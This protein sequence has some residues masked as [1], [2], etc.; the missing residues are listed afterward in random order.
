VEI[1]VIKGFNAR[2]PKLADGTDAGF[3]PLLPGSYRGEINADGDL[4][5]RKSNGDVALL[6]VH[7]RQEKI[8]GGFMVVVAT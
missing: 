1:Q 4:S 8:D 6:S 3:T 7:K 2:K 5:L